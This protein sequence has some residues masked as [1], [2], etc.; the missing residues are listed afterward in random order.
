MM[1][2]LGLEHNEN[3]FSE[4][5]AKEEQRKMSVLGLDFISMCLSVNIDRRA[6]IGQLLTHPFL[7]Q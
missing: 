5:N 4:S 2:M 1:T 6:E 3:R 7:A